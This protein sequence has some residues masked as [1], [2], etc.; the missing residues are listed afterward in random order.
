MLPSHPPWMCWPTD[1]IIITDVR[2]TIMEFS[3]PLSAM[4][5]S[6]LPNRHTL[7]SCGSGF[8]RDKYIFAHKNRIALRTASR[9]PNLQRYCRAHQL[10]RWIA[11][12]WFLRHLLH[13]FATTGAA[14]HWKT[15]WLAQSYRLWNHNVLKVF[16]MTLRQAKTIS[17]GKFQFNIESYWTLCSHWQLRYTCGRDC[18]V[19]V[20]LVLDIHNV[21][22]Y[23]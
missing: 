15:K 12:D 18:R 14:C 3:A 2:L 6:P 20:C 8:R 4:L 9:G 11:S 13:V 23:F 5:H 16:L 17:C 7:L 1:T 22:R 21:Y 19:H 10:F